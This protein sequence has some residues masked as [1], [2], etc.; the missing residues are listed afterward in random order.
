MTTRR[1]ISLNVI[2][3]ISKYQQ[4]FAK[5]PGYTMSVLYGF[6]MSFR[7]MQNVEPKKFEIDK[8]HQEWERQ[9]G[10]NRNYA[11]FYRYADVMRAAEREFKD[12]S[13]RPNDSFEEIVK[14][15]E[16]KSSILIKNKNAW[17][18]FCAINSKKY[19]GVMNTFKQVCKEN[20]HSDDETQT[21]EDI[22]REITTLCS[23]TP[24]HI[25]NNYTQPSA[26]LVN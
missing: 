10:L 7:F 18:L 14:F 3:D 4:Q 19:G 26:P 23:T 5:I 8:C 25:I 22:E 24:Q 15:K 2:A 12:F 17:N 21:F 16:R 13:A 6:V 20:T 9:K 11:D 1:D